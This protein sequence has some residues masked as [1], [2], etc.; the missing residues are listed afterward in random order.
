MPKHSFDML[1]LSTAMTCIILGCEENPLIPIDADNSKS[2]LC[3]ILCGKV[4]TTDVQLAPELFRKVE[5][6]AYWRQSSMSR[7]R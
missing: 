5:E 2:N 6:L 1:K 4:R 3:E 7:P